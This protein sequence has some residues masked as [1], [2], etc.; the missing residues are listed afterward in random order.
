MRAGTDGGRTRLTE[1]HLKIVRATIIDFKAQHP[2]VAPALGTDLGA[3]L[4]RLLWLEW[5]IDWALRECV[6]P[7][8]MYR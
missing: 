2:T 8:F 5:W 7:T 4:G 6:R 3:A 1:R